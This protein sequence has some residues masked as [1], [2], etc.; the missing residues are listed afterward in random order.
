MR[1]YFLL[2][3]LALWHWNLTDTHSWLARWFDPVAGMKLKV[4]M[5]PTSVE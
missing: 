3:N 1:K 5:R 4:V 2:G